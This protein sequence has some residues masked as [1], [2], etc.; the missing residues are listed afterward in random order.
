MDILATLA[1]TAHGNRYVV[2]ITYKCSNLTSVIPTGQITTTNVAFKIIHGWIF[3]YGVATNVLTDS[4]T[5]FTSTYFATR[6]RHLGAKQLATKIYHSQ[7]N[8]KIKRYTKEVVTP[9][10]RYVADR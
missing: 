4:G 6:R 5:Q 10:R 1:E 9:L 8:G 7:S 2:V 3:Q